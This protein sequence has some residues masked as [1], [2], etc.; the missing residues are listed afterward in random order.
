MRFI[1]HLDIVRCWERALR[2]AS[3]PLEY[4]Q[5][6]TAHPRIAVA[7][8]LAVGVTSEA[9]LMDIW[10]R[11]WLPPQSVMM[12]LRRQLPV[13]FSVLEA[14]DVPGSAP[15]LQAMVYGASYVCLA[16]HEQGIEAAR[17]AVQHFL[18]S[19]SCAHE[20]ARGD[21]SRT[22]DLRPLVHQLEIEPGTEEML[23]LSLVVSAG[24]KGSARPDHVLTVLGFTLPADSITRTGLFLAHPETGNGALPPRAR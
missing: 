8:P 14:F 24:Q 5:G 3:I 20:F 17:S 10:L 18:A 2:R 4:S 12:L 19:E 16:Q 13:G 11:K 6:F 22:V 7:A 21:E 1:S 23:R 9:E 15:A